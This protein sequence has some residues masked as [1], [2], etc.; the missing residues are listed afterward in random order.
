MNNLFLSGK[1]YNQ[2][3]ITTKTGT[4]MCSFS[5]GFY[6]PKGD[7]KTQFASMVAFGKTAELVL[8]KTAKGDAVIINGAISVEKD[9]DGKSQTK[10]VANVVERV[11][12]GRMNEQSST[13]DTPLDNKSQ[14]YKKKEE[15]PWKLPDQSNLPTF[16]AD[17]IPF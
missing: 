16:T 8:E 14:S 1:I 5:V 15:D 10:I 12:Q 17:D 9:R 3:E 4:K 13:E 7:E 11:F 2:K 6:A